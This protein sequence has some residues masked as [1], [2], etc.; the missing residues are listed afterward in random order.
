MLNTIYR[1]FYPGK[2]DSEIRKNYKIPDN[3]KFNLQM[4][5]DGYI[6]I[7]SEELPGFTAEAKNSGE[8]L[9]ALNDALMVYFDVPKKYGDIAFPSLTIEGHGTI[10][11][12]NKKLQLA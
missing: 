12:A 7:S 11:Y 9:D 3:I 6:V 10:S 8:V 4:F 2:S 1:F 5:S